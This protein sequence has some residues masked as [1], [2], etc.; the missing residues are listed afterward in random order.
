MTKI[1]ISSY[2]PKTYCNEC[3]IIGYNKPSTFRNRKGNTL[4]Y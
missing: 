4:F 1:A 2:I 3:E